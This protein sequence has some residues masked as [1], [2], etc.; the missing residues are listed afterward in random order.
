LRFE[1]RGAADAFEFGDLFN[2]SEQAMG[3]AIGANASR[4]GRGVVGLEAL[5]SRLMGAIVRALVGRP[6]CGVVSR[7]FLASK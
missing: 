4:A 7:I 1:F 6:I 5:W 2:E 3:V